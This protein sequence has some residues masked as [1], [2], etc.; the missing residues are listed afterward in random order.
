ME[1]LSFDI[2]SFPV[3]TKNGNSCVLVVCD[4]FIKWT[5]CFALPNHQ[6]PT[7]A[8]CLVTEL[9]LRFGTPRFLHSDQAPEF[10]SK[11]MSE[12]CKLLEIRKTYTT[13]YRPQSDGLVERFNRTLISMLSK[14][15]EFVA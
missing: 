15:C 11:L 3:E 6:A 7:V 5:E 8:D 9:F 14:F 10:T 2:L 1:R 4:H 13:P 12:I